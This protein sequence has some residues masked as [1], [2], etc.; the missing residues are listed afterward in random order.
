[1]G[2]LTSK[3]R[4]SKHVKQQRHGTN[5]QKG[6]SGTEHT[7]HG[8]EPQSRL[9]AQ[10]AGPHTPAHG[11]TISEKRAPLRVIRKSFGKNAGKPDVRTVYNLTT[12]RTHV[13]YADG[14]LVHNCDAFTYACLQHDGGELLGRGVMNQRREVKPVSLAGWV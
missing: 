4:L 6:A 9:S 12:S 14:I 3:A 8:K 1:M 10:S 11:L 7:R 5:P 2:G 13:Y